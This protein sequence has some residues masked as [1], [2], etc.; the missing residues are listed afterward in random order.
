MNNVNDRAWIEA[1]TLGELV[2]RRGFEFGDRDAIVFPDE[3]VTFAELAARTD[4]IAKGLLAAGVQPGDRVGYFM[5]DC[6]EALVILYGAAKVGASVVPVNN[7]FKSFELTRVIAHSGVSVLFTAPPMPGSADFVGLIHET[8]PGLASHKAGNGDIADFPELRHVIVLGDESSPGMSPIDEFEAAGASV[9]D[10]DLIQRSQTVRIRDT[11]VIMYTSGTTAAPKGAMISH[12]AF[13]RYAYGTVHHRMYLTPED[14]IWTVLPLFHIGGVAFAVGTLYSGS[15]YVHSGF[16]NPEAVVRQLEEERCTIAL[17]GFET[18][19]LPVVNHPDFPNA[20][21]SAL[22]IVMCVGVPERLRDIQNRHPDASVVNTFGQTEACAFLSLSLPDDDLELR[23]TTGGHPLPGMEAK[24]TD[25]ESGE[26]LPTG[27]LGELCYR[28][29]NSFDGYFRDDA[30]TDSVFDE[31]GYFHTGDLG[32]KDENGRITFI[33]RLKDMLKVGG[34]NVAAAEVEGYL[35]GHPAVTIAQ[36]VAAPDAK[37]TEVPAAFIELAP[38]AEVTEQEIIDFCR[39]KIATFRVPR[40]I[41]F[42]DEWPMSGT[43]V[44][45]YVLREQIAAELEEKGIS[46]APRIDSAIKAE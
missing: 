42:V 39:G 1:T 16:F 24:V 30:L 21:I 28:G 38:G 8:M 31:D 4:I 5:H 15:A 17:P 26:I 41:R 9:S 46:Q 35:I 29:P 36:V 6:V 3:R 20:D 34:E 2:D 19:W 32:T 14:R 7:R 18:I 43:K 13:C 22:R 33:T 12:E 23:M 11:A 45:K 44:K 27:E 10:S 40:Y 37:Y 25:P